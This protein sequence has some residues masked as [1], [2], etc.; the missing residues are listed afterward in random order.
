MIKKY[1][2]LFCAIFLFF[3]SC[4]KKEENATTGSTTP[5]TPNTATGSSALYIEVY[6]RPES[7][8]EGTK[9]LVDGCYISDTAT[10]PTSDTCTI[11]IP[12]LTMHYSDIIFKVGTNS[13]SQC[14]MVSFRPYYYLRSTNAAF[15]PV[16]GRPTETKDCSISGSEKFCYGGAAPEIVP[17]FGSYTGVYF[18]TNAS[19]ETEYT[20]PSANTRYGT[21]AADSLTTNADI[22]NTLPSGSRGAPFVG[23][24]VTYDGGGIYYDYRVFC[25]DK[26]AGTRFSITLTL[27]DHDTEGTPSS[28]DQFYDWGL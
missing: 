14:D 17:S 26:W 21:S 11:N 9:T 25:Y 6:T 22:A 28:V 18:L 2:I 16:A 27:G 7:T 23:S 5:T 10:V 8:P 4:G 20:L 1:V 13:T 3:I 19:I 24:G 15:V 12:E